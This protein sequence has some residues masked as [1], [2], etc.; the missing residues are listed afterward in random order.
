MGLI[1]KEVTFKLNFKVA[2]YYIDLGYATKANEIIT[3]KV[4][5]L[6]SGSNYKVKVECDCCGKHYEIP[7]NQYTRFNHN[8]KI[9]CHNCSHKVLN[10]REN[11]YLWNPNKTDE[12]RI[13]DRH[14][15]EYS[16]F[17]RRVLFRD[18]YMCQCCGAKNSKDNKLVVHHLDGYNWC[19]EKRT[20]DT[21]G[22][23]LCE[24]CHKKFH[25][26]YG[27]GNNTKEQFEK[28]IGR[29][30]ELLKS[31]Y[32]EPIERKIYC[33]EEDKIYESCDEFCKEKG[34]TRQ[35]VKRVC[36]INSKLKVLNGLHL[37]YLDVY[38]NMNED[39][40]NEYLEL[41][42]RHKVVCVEND[43]IFDSISEASKKYKIAQSNIIECCCGRLIRA[44]G[45][46]WRYLEDYEKLTEKEIEDLINSRRQECRKVICIETKKVFNSISE[47]S[48]FYNI[49]GSHIS[50]CCSGKSITC[51]GNHWMYLEDYEKIENKNDIK[52]KEDKKNRKIVCVENGEH[53]D[54]I[55][56]ASK[57]YNISH[58]LIQTCCSGLAK[59]A[60]G[61]HWKYLEDYEK[62][63]K[64]EK[65]EIIN[66]EYKNKKKIIC[67]KNKQIFNSIKEICEFLHTDHN[68][69]RKHCLNK[70]PIKGVYVLYL[71]DYE[72]M[73]EEEIKK[74]I[75]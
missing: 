40:L 20:D 67:I 51:F 53:F 71:E 12:E 66:Y 3:V 34:V 58:C 2:K 37:F 48:K 63:T 9:Y 75:S 10:G 26:D 41:K 50:S 38:E 56:D 64:K 22:I 59:S 57:K 31:S 27:H 61:L 65:E 8:G 49:D 28:W 32:I 68:T 39:E 54:T 6:T 55:T 17:I 70:K 29:P 23:T 72:K 42:N 5:D 16:L 69:I 35:E 44:K 21:N 46:H 52:F 36:N 11:H 25:R 1:T 62:L 47:A 13:K 24:N 33:L 74:L 15:P 19:V 18:Y 4:E 14:Y 60:G 7:Y 45:L 73:S 43:E 30:I